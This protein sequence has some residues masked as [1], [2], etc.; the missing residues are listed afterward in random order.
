MANKRGKLAGAVGVGNRQV[1]GQAM[2]RQQAGSRTGDGSATGGQSDRR[3]VGNRRAV[4]QAMGR[5]QAGSWTG[6][7]WQQAGSRTGDGSA[8]GF[9]NRRVVRQARF[10]RVDWTGSQYFTTIWRRLAV[11]L[12][13][14]YRRQMKSRCGDYFSQVHESAG[15]DTPPP[16][17]PGK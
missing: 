9:G 4:G 7:D 8:T 2:G 1:V 3:W 13:L 15:T 17:L 12:P 5:Q 6:D 16:A 14:K 11:W 10:G